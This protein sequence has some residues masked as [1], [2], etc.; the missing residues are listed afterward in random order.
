MN[1]LIVALAAIVASSVAS[2]DEPT[3]TARRVVRFAFDGCEYLNTIAPD[4]DNPGRLDKK[5]AAHFGRI[6]KSQLDGIRTRYELKTAAFEGW[7]VSYWVRGVDIEFPAT[8]SITIG[9]L[10]RYL[11]PDEA[12]DGDYAMGNASTNSKSDVE[13]RE[14]NP[15][16]EGYCYVTV[17]AEADRKKGAQRRVFSLRFAD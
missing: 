4:P 5:L 10:Q 15:K 13:V 16:R 2:A 17:R 6:G 11:G 1:R 7:T 14:F 8:I 9:D 12:Q 3:G